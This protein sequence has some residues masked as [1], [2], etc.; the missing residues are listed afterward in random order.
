MGS[1]FTAEGT[2]SRSGLH[3]AARRGA[4]VET[5]GKIIALFPVRQAD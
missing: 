5:E 2:S 3:R 4:V 1:V